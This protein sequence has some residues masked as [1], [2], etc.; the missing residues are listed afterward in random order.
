VSG[1]ILIVAGETSGDAQAATLVRALRRRDPELLLYGVGGPRMREAG[2][3]VRIDIAELS[4][5]GLTEVV[6][7]LGRILGHL[8]DLR[9]QLRGPERPDLLVL[10]DFPDFNLRLAKAA[11]RAGVRVF[12]YISPQVWAWRRRRIDAICR[13]VDRMVVLFPFEEEL[14]RSRGL[15]A[16]FVGH[17]LAAEVRA[18]ADGATTRRRWGLPADGPVVALLPGSRHKEIAA[19]APAMLAAARELAADGVRCIVACAP[20]IDE[21]EIAA[22]ARAAGVEVVVSAGD[23]YNVVAAADLALVASG[24]ATV[25]CAVLGTPM[26]V[27][28]R[29][30]RMTY[31]IASRLVAVDF[32][33]MPNVLL[34]HEAVPELIQDEVTVERVAAE[35]RALLG[36]ATRRRHAR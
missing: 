34:G 36:D 12:Y 13:W 30:S 20:G 23:T 4:V 24:T 33:A 21:A 31:A 6:G 18:D 16:R 11:H 7:G 22:M 15:D 32:I 8:R 19:L 26:V 9:R 1:R 10:V 14:Y 25:E 35:A 17:P 5:M 27:L 29:M 28:Y 2:V 3:D